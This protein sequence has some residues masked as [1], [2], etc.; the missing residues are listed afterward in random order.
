M[1]KVGF[2]EALVRI[3]KE[4][5][6]YHAEAYFFVREALAFTSRML[7]KPARGPQ[8]HLTAAELLDGMRQYALREYGPMA[9]TVLDY[10]GVRNCADFGQ[11]VFHLVDK[12]ILRK[13]ENDSIRDFEHGYDFKEAFRGPY[14]RQKAECGRQN[15]E[16]KI[17]NHAE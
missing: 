11:I 7:K 10:W 1:K 8:R 5:R 6:R 15:E 12:N 2:N 3:L 17:K 9:M 13:T 14:L 4:D 16:C